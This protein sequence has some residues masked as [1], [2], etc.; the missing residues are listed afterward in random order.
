MPEILVSESGHGASY[1]SHLEHFP[2][3]IVLVLYFTDILYW[4]NT[5]SVEKFMKAKL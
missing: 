2:G 4:Q 5:S 3:V 1:V